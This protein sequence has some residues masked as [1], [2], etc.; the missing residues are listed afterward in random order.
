MNVLSNVMLMH[1]SINCPYLIVLLRTEVTQEDIIDYI[2]LCFMSYIML[3]S[4]LYI[5]LIPYYVI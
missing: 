3:S 2:M 1:Y 5:R 4:M